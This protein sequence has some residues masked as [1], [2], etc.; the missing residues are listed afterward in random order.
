MSPQSNP[1]IP[2]NKKTNRGERKNIEIDLAE[3][4][5]YVL[6][7]AALSEEACEVVRGHRPRDVNDIELPLRVLLL[8]L[9]LGI[10][11]GGL[12]IHFLYRTTGSEGALP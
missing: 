3:K 11:R 10:V 8:Y 2:P 5:F 6:D 9:P 1:V 7:R 4:N 12:D